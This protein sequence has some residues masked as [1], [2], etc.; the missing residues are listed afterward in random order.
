MPAAEFMPSLV[1]SPILSSALPP[2]PDCGGKMAH[3]A[4]EGVSQRSLRCQ[5][6]GYPENIR[7][8]FR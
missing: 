2:C 7:F 4:I 1:L 5:E 6:C 3:A 8:N